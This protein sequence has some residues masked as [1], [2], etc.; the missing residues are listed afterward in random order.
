M[1]C[2]L[3][4]IMAPMFLVSNIA[5][6]VAGSEHGIIGSF[7][8]LNARPVDTLRDWLQEIQNRTNKPYA[9]NLVVHR[10]NPY[11]AQQLKI[12]LEK[13]V[14][15]IIASLGDP[16]EVIREAHQIGTKVF[17]DVVNLEHAQKA[18]SKGA[19]GLIAVASGA[20]GHAGNISPFVLIPYLLQYVSVP[21]LA[22]GGIG[23]GATLAA[24]LALGSSGVS[25]G[26]R[27][28]ASQECGVTEDYKNAIVHSGPEDIVTTYKLDGVP[29]NVIHT[30]Y[31]KKIG[32]ELNWMERWLLHHRQFRAW[33]LRLRA[34]KSFK[35]LQQAIEKPTWKQVW[36]AGQTVGIIQEIAPI[37]SIIAQIQQEYIAAIQ[38]LPHNLL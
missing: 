4:I 6:V 35:M 11:Y 27:F 31:V 23:N 15:M 12:C 26:T 14:P 19:D 3:P 36:G 8:A 7:P 32:T 13:K 22:A 1:G 33:I 21:I 37:P 34:W 17:C 2:D 25:M 18:V 24:A 38:Q 9:V 5:M 29:A 16:A 30:P 10:S 20:G 28:I